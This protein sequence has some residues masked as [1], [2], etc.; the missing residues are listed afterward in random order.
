MA[1]K[2]SSKEAG[3]IQKAKDAYPKENYKRGQ[4]S[5]KTF[6]IAKKQG[7]IKDKTQLVATR[8]PKEAKMVKAIQVNRKNDLSKTAGRAQLIE[9]RARA[10]KKAAASKRKSM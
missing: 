5:D 7:V 10:V 6:S 1:R 9:S 3:K 4:Y 2:I 8:S